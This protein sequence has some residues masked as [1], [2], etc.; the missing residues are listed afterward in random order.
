MNS[1]VC[2]YCRNKKSRKV[3]FTP[4]GK[5][6][7]Y[8][9]CCGKKFTEDTVRHVKITC[10]H[11]KT[12]TIKR[13]GKTSTGMQRY[14]CK[15][16]KK[17]FSD[18]H[19]KVKIKAVCPECS[20][21]HIIKNG[22]NPNGVQVYK[23]VTCS[24]KFILDKYKYQIKDCPECHYTYARKCGT[25]RGEQYY[26]CMSCHRKFKDN[27]KVHILSQ[28]DLKIIRER[29]YDGCSR[30]EL[31]EEYG[32]SK[33]LIQE[34][35]K[36]IKSF[37]DS[38]IEFIKSALLVG[39]SISKTAKEYNVSEEYV[40]RRAYSLTHKESLTRDEIASIIEYGKTFNI[41]VDRITKYVPSNMRNK[42]IVR[43]LY[44]AE[45]EKRR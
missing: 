18:R 35:T 31:A 15:S 17:W 19:V 32:V 2:P 3:G 23:C 40:K 30:A 37:E 14:Y 1:I 20:G 29:L 25:V 11:C 22:R 44:K 16:C 12:Q 38:K 43:E 24:R 27:Y 9:K 33:R 7:Y 21:T 28:S 8:C 6:R 5:Q 10:P 39:W 45:L 36:D 4:S 34:H 41:T 13:A 42:E 26:E